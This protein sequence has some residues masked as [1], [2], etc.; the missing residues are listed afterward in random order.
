MKMILT[1]E[2]TEETKYNAK[3]N[4]RKTKAKRKLK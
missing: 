4:K 2:M 3:V 1:L